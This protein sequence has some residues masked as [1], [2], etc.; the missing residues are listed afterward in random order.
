MKQLCVA[1]TGL[2]RGENPQPGAGIIRSLR[3]AWP[4]L[5][6]LGLVYDVMES[7]IYAEDGPDE[8]HLMPYP[9]SGV[10]AFFERLDAVHSWCPID[11]LIPTL[12]AE[13][14][15]LVNLRQEFARRGIQV[16]LPEANSL[17]RRAKQNLPEL[18][19][20]C[21]VAVPKTVVLH[22]TARTHQAVA[23][24]GMPLLVKGPYYDAQLVYNTAGVHAAATH[25]LAEWGAPVILQQRVTGPEF[26]VMGIGD[27]MGNI[28][29][30]CSVRKTIVSDKGKG[31]GAIVVRDET[32][33]RLCGKLIRELCW[34]GPFE[35]ELI[36]DTASGGYVL[37]E[38][39]PRFPAWVDFPSMLGSNFAA[40]LLEVILE[41]HISRA[42]PPCRPGAFFVRH[43]IEVVGD[44]SNYGGLIGDVDIDAVIAPQPLS[45]FQPACDEVVDSSST[46]TR[47]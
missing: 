45:L 30:Q 28:V 46:G 13:I 40:A 47:S 43:Q 33:D 21:D 5:H 35:I 16:F 44:V 32:L 38:I 37:I 36:R 20:A 29:A 7:G 11:I 10:A 4:S 18:A 3:R 17:Q 2:Q 8:V 34:R 24:L 6:I 1:V 14:A 12:D 31:L 42:M 15:L 27:G 41:G 26:N 19:E 23:D 39:N 25:L 9:S 22:D